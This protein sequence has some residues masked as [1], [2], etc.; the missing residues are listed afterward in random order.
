[1]FDGF[2]ELGGV[3]IINVER[4]QRY[5][6]NVAPW[7]ALPSFDKY[8]GLHL[9]LGD[10]QY[11]SPLIDSAE[12][13]TTELGEFGGYT[14]EF[15]VPA[16]TATHRFYGF[17]PLGPFTGIGDS[18]RTAVATEGI[19]DGGQVGL[20]RDG[21]RTIR[22]HG[23]LI[24]ADEMAAE[25]GLSWLRAAIR[26]D[27]CTMHDSA[28]GSADL[29]YFLDFPEVCDIW[30]KGHS[31]GSVD[32]GAVTVA[33]SPLEA[34]LRTPDDNLVYDSQW[35]FTRRDGQIVEWGARDTDGRI[36]E[37]HGPVV[38][39][40]S[41]YAPNPS[42]T[43]DATGWTAATST[44]TRVT[45]GGVDGGA[46]GHL[47]ENTPP[48]VRF[49]WIPDPA[50]VNASPAT[51]GWR[52]LGAT[53]AATST[54][55]PT[56]R[57]AVFTKGGSDAT[58]SA[59]VSLFGPQDGPIASKVSFWVNTHAS[60]LTATILDNLGAVVHTESIAAASAG[61]V[62]F[63]SVIGPNYILLLSSPEASI[64][65]ADML[66]EEGATAGT[67]FSG[68]NTDTGT[69]DYSWLGTPL[70]SPS[71]FRHGALTS[72][73][74][75][76]LTPDTTFDVLADSFYLRSA[77][78]AQLTAEI[79]SL[80]DSTVLATLPISVPFTWTRYTLS[81]EF[82]RN[83]KIVLSGT[84]SYDIDEV[85]TES[86]V[87][88]A[89]AY[90][91]GDT[92]AA[93]G[94]QITWLAGPGAST[95]RQI[96]INTVA[97]NEVDANHPD[98]STA[99]LPIDTESQEL[100]IY[101][102]ALQGI[103][104]DPTS[105]YGVA[106]PVDVDTQIEPVQRR[107]HGVYPI[108]GPTV[109]GRYEMNQ[110]GAAIEVDFLLVAETPF[111]YGPTREI[112]DDWTSLENYLYADP[113]SG[114]N[115]AANPSFE[116][117]TTGLAAVPGTSGVAAA[118]SA[119]PA[120]TTAF[121]SKVGRA[122]WTTAQTAS[123]AGI[124]YQTPYG[125]ITPGQFYSFEINHFLASIS[126]N[127]VMYANWVTSSGAYITQAGLLDFSLAAGTIK[128]DGLVLSGLAPAGASAIQIGILNLDPTT[129]GGINHPFPIGGYC[130]IDGIMVNV[131]YLPF[132]Y[133]DGAS[134]AGVDADGIDYTYAW[135][136][137]ANASSSTRT[138]V[139]ESAPSLIDPALPVVP[140][141][142]DAPDVTD[143]AFPDQTQWRRYLIPIPKNDVAL[144]ASTVP[145]V[146]L[147]SKTQEIRQVR[148]RFYPNPFGLDADKVDPLYYCGESIIS[149]IPPSTE[150][151][152]DGVTEHGFASVAGSDT[153][154]ADSL[155]YGTGGYPM[156]WPEMSCGTDYVMSVD[157]LPT[158]STADLDLE[159]EVSLRE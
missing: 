147:N 139:V 40:R 20:S 90:F 148:L 9:A 155:L 50:F 63:S 141:P 157:I 119:T 122:T 24:G 13:V 42:F 145:T 14:G 149:Y 150:L 30:V 52:L 77:L 95:S 2:L 93:E 1:M 117:N 74:L 115:L 45:T 3:E 154:P 59:E 137:T 81:T 94:Y 144:W 128:S 28:C 130:E 54:G 47:A 8:D 23:V 111:A 35:L 58:L 5:I 91:D 21:T 43:Y 86:G 123:N 125:S 159:L 135:V 109:L 10:K 66:V 49:N 29:R 39:Q 133:F 105:A 4:T 143:I 158:L 11:E 134:A 46:Y 15:S 79:V 138:L 26:N 73:S 60:T 22:V 152:V 7:L 72:H 67:F 99:V 92:V 51:S 62:N 78:G 132:R 87:G 64:T 153:Q 65:I 129:G 151:I 103:V 82:G 48:T 146:T 85:L 120:V 56:A 61:R 27:D 44:L 6:R 131:G 140:S 33:N 127:F 114:A 69:D 19:L 124:Y 84:G 96:W 75:T 113:A 121:G 31:S 97:Q 32:Y 37:H 107:Y 100:R 136:S 36:S 104:A 101:L 112:I 88:V 108:Q 80:V 71:R 76:T 98:G 106:T 89:G 12:W 126:T 118:T 17:Y 102:T 38:I 83:T 110:G 70:I 16:F 156:S 25:A 41:N 34:D 116:T 55:G 53:T 142:P 68:D 18:T 57:K